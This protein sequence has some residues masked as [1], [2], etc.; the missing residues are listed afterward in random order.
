MLINPLQYL[1][2]ALQITRR[3]KWAFIA[4]CYIGLCVTLG[5][6]MFIV[7]A[8]FVVLSLVAYFRDKE[9]E[10]RGME[11][12]RGNWLFFRYGD[13]VDQTV[14]PIRVQAEWSAAEIYQF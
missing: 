5:Y 8:P 3:F 10:E 2:L 13:E 4:M 14:L 6:R 7:L 9:R 12:F 11:D 1:Q